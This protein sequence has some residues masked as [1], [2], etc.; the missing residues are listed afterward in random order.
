M[1]KFKAL[2]K[3]NKHILTPFGERVKKFDKGVLKA[4]M[5]G[6]LIVLT[7][8]PSIERHLLKKTLRQHYGLK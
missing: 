5:E 4:L 3:L 2:L 6:S 8:G 1:K 7:R